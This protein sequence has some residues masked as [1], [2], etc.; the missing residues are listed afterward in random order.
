MAPAPFMAKARASNKS[1]PGMPSMTASPV[2]TAV[3][4]LLNAR[5]GVDARDKHWH[6]ER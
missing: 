1:W 6:D 2:A 4:V 5:K 3:H